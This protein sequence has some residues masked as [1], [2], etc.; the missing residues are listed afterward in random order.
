MYAS[1]ILHMTSTGTGRGDDG[2][3]EK[4][5]LCYV[6]FL[7]W[8]NAWDCWIPLHSTTSRIYTGADNNR[9][10][11]YGP[12][13]LDSHN[14]QFAIRGQSPMARAA[15]AGGAYA[16]TT[17]DRSMMTAAVLNNNNNTS[18]RW[19]VYGYEQWCTARSMVYY[20]ASVC[21]PHYHHRTFIRYDMALSWHFLHGTRR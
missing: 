10:A 3:D 1:R 7:R 11:P 12:H 4:Q 16:T 5:R 18:N 2:T 17:T 13:G 20:D 8:S 19:S 21:Q 9:I 14:Q 15:A 6:H